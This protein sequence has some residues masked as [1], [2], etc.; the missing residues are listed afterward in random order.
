MD[1]ITA[2]P[3]PTVWISFLTYI[4]NADGTICVCIDPK[5]L[6]KAIIHECQKTS[7]LEKVV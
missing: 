2:E 7:V 3:V 1:I 4:Q 5:G 6:N